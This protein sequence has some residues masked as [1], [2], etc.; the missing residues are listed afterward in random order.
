MDWLTPPVTAENDAEL[1]RRLRR[2]NTEA[3][4][5]LYER[6]GKL[7]FTLI[8]NIV[9]NREVAEDLLTETLL[10]AS[11]RI[12]SFETDSIPVG[13]WLLVLARNHALKFRAEMGADGGNVETRS[14]LEAPGLFPS[15]ASTEADFLGTEA[16]RKSFIQLPE[17]D[18]LILELAWFEGLT[19]D[20]IALRLARPVEDVMDS[21][22]ESLA[23]LREC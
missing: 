23:L 19:I 22:R 4:G 10:M 13:S 12:Q 7:L 21:A 1:I 2:R 20:E 18:R 15:K 16:A 8:L 14:K 5:E 6:Y 3:M 11:N 9:G 17:E